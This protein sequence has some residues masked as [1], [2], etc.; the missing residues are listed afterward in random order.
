MAT[1]LNRKNN[2]EIP[3]FEKASVYEEKCHIQSTPCTGPQLSGN[4]AD[5]IK[6]FQHDVAGSYRDSFLITKNTLHRILYRKDLKVEQTKLSYKN[7]FHHHQLTSYTHASQLQLVKFYQR[8]TV[9]ICK[10]IT[11]MHFYSKNYDCSSAMKTKISKS[12]DL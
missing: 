6:E 11:V 8:V 10:I 9:V 5:M 7:V 3:I 12:V 2:S 4:T 1:T